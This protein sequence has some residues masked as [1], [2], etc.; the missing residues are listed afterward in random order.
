MK[1]SRG[2]IEKMNHVAYGFTTYTRAQVHHRMCLLSNDQVPLLTL[3]YLPINF[4]LYFIILLEVF[5]SLCIYHRC[6]YFHVTV[7]SHVGALYER[8][9]LTYLS[10][11]VI[12]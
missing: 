6:T 3:K 12:R 5:I 11:S 9:D 7:S 1:L 10:F 4:T 8:E 2:K